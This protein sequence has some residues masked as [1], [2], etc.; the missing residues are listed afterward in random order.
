MMRSKWLVLSAA[1]LALAAWSGN[2]CAKTAETTPEMTALVIVDIQEF[3]FPGGALPLVGPEEAAANA[4]RLLAQFRARGLPVVHVGHNASSGKAFHADVMPIQGEK[5]IYKDE[6][7]AFKGTD[8]EA[9]LRAR[10]VTRL[11]IC[12]MQTHMCAE[13]IVRAAADRGFEVVMIGDACATRDLTYGGRTVA[14]ADVHAATLATV[15]RYYGKV[16]TTDAFLE[17]LAA[18]GQ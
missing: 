15:D 8:L 1:F 2:L 18:A 17:Q 12:G 6:V 9:Y 14:A 16:M 13:A 4:S 11:V 10:G 3:Y 5:I 7:N